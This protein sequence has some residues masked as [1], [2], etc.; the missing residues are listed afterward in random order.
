MSN[1]KSTATLSTESFW[2]ETV[3]PPVFS[4]LDS[5]LKTEVLVVGCGITGL[6]AAYLL[7]RQGKQVT[8]I[9][10]GGLWNGETPLTTAH[11]TEQMDIGYAEIERMHG[12]ETARSVF[13]SQRASLRFIEDTAAELKIACGFKRVDG[14]LFLAPDAE[15]EV[16]EK[17]RGALYR[18]GW[19]D[20]E[21]LPNAHTAGF[22]TGPCL[23][24]PQQAQFHPLKYLSALTASILEHGGRIYT[25]T[26]AA[27]IESG[28]VT[29]DR[30]HVIAADEILVTTHSPVKN[31]FFFLKEAAYRTYVVA[32][33]IPRGSVCPALYWDTGDPYHYVRVTEKNGEHDMLIVGGE[34][35]KTGQA[36]DNVDRYANLEA[37][38]RARFPQLDVI[39]HRWSGQ[40]IE[41]VD[42]LPYIGK[43]PYHRGIYIATGYSGNGMT[44]GTLA[45][46]LLTD[47]VSGASSEW[48]AL[49]NPTRK[50]LWSGKDFLQ[51][52]LNAAQHL[53]GD[54][55]KDEPVTIEDL[56]P[57]EGGVVRHGLMKVA[58]YRD[59]SGKLT[60][61]SAVCTHLGCIVQWNG[62]ERSFDCPC[63]GSRFTSEG[64]VITG[65]AIRD[66]KQISAPD[67]EA[68]KK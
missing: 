24:F 46:L 39:Q 31:I 11:L 26:H 60:E 33:E 43:S 8:L 6:T 55:L 9:D 42:G 52:N 65:P 66:L 63:H 64:Q 12:G 7:T 57:G 32:G 38:A 16:L 36:D 18:V 67:R 17:E 40:V 44:Q 50:N 48:E 61:C 28:R 30:H 19:T 25:H 47:L 35:H 29:T 51:E 37:W 58:A 49:Y 2:L 1:M 62:A 41:P 4:A 21:L 5:N 53:I 68:L 20:V 54:Y 59:A 34:D 45:G 22:T 15:Q 14:Y 23:R 27:Q 10:S 56:K 13:R 3:A